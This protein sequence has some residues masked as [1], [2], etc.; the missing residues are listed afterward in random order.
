VEGLVHRKSSWRF[1][2]ATLAGVAPTSFLL[3][4]FGGEMASDNAQRI[5]TTAMI[6]FGFTAVPVIVKL[7]LSRRHGNTETRSAPSAEAA[8]SHTLLRHCLV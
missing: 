6:L 3:A 8:P 4:H 7:I 1:A 5:V 2:I